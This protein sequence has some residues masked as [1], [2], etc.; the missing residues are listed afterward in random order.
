[1]DDRG[2]GSEGQDC[3]P[4]MQGL[5]QRPVPRPDDDRPSGQS[6]RPQVEVVKV[7]AVLVDATLDLV[8]ILA[9]AGEA[10]ADGGAGDR[11]PFVRKAAW[12][13]LDY[14]DSMVGGPTFTFLDGAEGIVH[15]AGDAAVGVMSSAGPRPS[16]LGRRP[17][18]LLRW[19]PRPLLRWRPRPLLRWRPRPLLRWRPRPLLRWRPRPLLRWRP[20]PL[21]RQHPRPL[22]RWR[23]RLM[24]GWRPR[25]TLLRWRPWPMLR[26]RPRPTLLRRRPWS[27]L[28]VL[29]P[30]VWRSRK[31]VMSRVIQCETMMTIFMMSVMMRT[32]TILTMMIRR[33]LIITPMCMVL[34]NLMIMSCIMIF[35]DRMIVLCSPM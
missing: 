1:M 31:S 10:G 23:P 5:V 21:L 16:L 25:A 2:S 18:P 28:L 7:S 9:L 19:R 3:F 11:P 35:L 22:L 27:T 20:R 6:G 17:R 29:I 32:L 13:D 34:L 8:D 33:I 15:L 26:W 30:P 12:A 14:Y 24:L 4:L